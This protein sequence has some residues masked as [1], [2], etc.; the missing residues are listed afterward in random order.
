MRRKNLA[1]LLTVSLIVLSFGFAAGAV[2]AKSAA[3]PRIPLLAQTDPT[4]VPADQPAASSLALSPASS[5]IATGVGI[6]AM[7]TE[8]SSIRLDLPPTDTNNLA[9]LPHERAA[10]GGFVIGY[11][12][13]PIT[14]IEFSDFGCPHCEAYLPTLQR[15]FT[16]FVATGKAKFEYRVFPTAGGA[17]TD[18]TGKLL[19]CADE[20][21]AGAF[22]EGYT[23]MFDYVRQ[24]LYTQDV[25]RRFADDAG[26]DYS[27]ML[28]CTATANQV[29]ADI[30]FGMSLGVNG[31]PTIMVR[32]GDG[33]PDYITYKGSVYDRGAVPYDVLS[34]VI[35]LANDQ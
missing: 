9:S 26:L 32:Y 25:G 15:F 16:N 8:L 33:T 7:L 11:A 34:A 35:A 4:P 2:A 27:V 20:Q 6:A 5:F 12:D 3:H 19:E 31:T 21:R 13:A 1:F 23:L 10:D 14:V 22:W 29:S 17:L 18:F 30:A 28:Q 24:G